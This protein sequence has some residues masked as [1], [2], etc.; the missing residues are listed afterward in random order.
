M[1]RKECVRF[2]LC[3]VYFTRY[4][5]YWLNLQ[6]WKLSDFQNNV[7]L[8][9]NH[10]MM[11]IQQHGQLR[12]GIYCAD[13]RYGQVWLAQGEVDINSFF[14]I[15]KTRLKDNLLQEWYSQVEES[16]KAY[17]YKTLTVSLRGKN[18]CP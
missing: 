13:N 14:M 4:I 2:T 6:E 9:L 5:N 15:F 8:C 11:V 12:S 3:F 7:T 10:L 16:S 17:N 18:T 1:A